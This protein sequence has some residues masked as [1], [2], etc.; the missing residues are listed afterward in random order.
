M[1]P[2][3]QLPIELGRQCG[4]LTVMRLQ[5]YRDEHRSRHFDLVGDH[6]S[7]DLVTVT[8]AGILIVGFVGALVS[9]LVR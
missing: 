3:W 9:L 7:I 6:W 8:A 5:T 2:F 1:E 4:G